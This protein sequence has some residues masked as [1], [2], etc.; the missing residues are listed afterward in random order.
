MRTSVLLTVLAVALVLGTACK[1]PD[2]VD[3]NFYDFQVVARG[4]NVLPTP[5]DTTPRATA[6]LTGGSA[7]VQVVYSSALTVDS[8]FLYQMGAGALNYTVNAAGATTYVAPS[9]RVCGGGVGTLQ[10]GLVTTAP[11]ACAAGVALVAQP[12]TVNANPPNGVTTTN[13]ATS[14]T[15]SL[16][17]YGTQ[18]VFFSGAGAFYKRGTARGTPFTLP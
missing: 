5:A 4:A 11:S 17:A 2:T 13:T 1:G 18:M 6:A 7:S 8:I 10:T 16:R 14:I 9:A 12:T 15:N 3:E